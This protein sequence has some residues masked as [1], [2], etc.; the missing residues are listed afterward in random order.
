M[1]QLGATTWNNRER[2]RTETS[3]VPT[4]RRHPGTIEN[5]FYIAG[6]QV[7]AGSNPV[8]PT[9][10]ARVKAVPEKSG[11]AFS[12]PGLGPDLLERDSTTQDLLR[13]TMA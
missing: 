3:C 13:R 10:M 11:A 2:L 9:V 12:V 1:S 8:S 7:V 6:G 5:T 4:V